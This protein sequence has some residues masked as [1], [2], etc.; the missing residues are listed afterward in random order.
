MLHIIRHGHSFVEIT[1]EK[2]SYLVDPYI[3]DNP[4]C[5]V[6]VADVSAKTILGIFLTHGHGDHIG[7]TLAIHE[8]T[9]APIVCEYGVGAY[10]EKEHGLECVVGSIGG[11]VVS[12]DATIQ[13]FNA[14]H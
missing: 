9:K 3:T 2:G 6:S 11:K 14:P 13:F 10:F 4:K 1:T 7:D 5:D 12:G 8:V